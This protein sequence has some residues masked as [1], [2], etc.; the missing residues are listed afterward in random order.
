ML[1][2]AVCILS[3][4]STLRLPR[5]WSWL[6][7]VRHDSR[8]EKISQC[9]SMYICVCVWKC[10]FRLKSSNTIHR[11]SLLFCFIDL[12]SIFPHWLCSCGCNQSM[13]HSF[14]CSFLMFVRNME[15]IHPA[16]PNKYSTLNIW[17]I[18]ENAN[19]RMSIQLN[20]CSIGGCTAP[21][22][23]YQQRMPNQ[24]EWN[25]IWFMCWIFPLVFGSF[26]NP[27]KWMDERMNEWTNNCVFVT[28]NLFG[29]WRYFTS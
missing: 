4:S 1:S 5:F 16:L 12:L 28:L 3:V 22:I 7:V 9:L 6:L 11:L 13:W 29:N 10:E 17:F 15:E 18:P 24:F 20:C 8:R 2:L 23:A 25:S 19:S 27:N 26:Y 21:S 14:L